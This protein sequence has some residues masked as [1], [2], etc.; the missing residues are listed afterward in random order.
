[1]GNKIKQIV[2]SVFA[3]PYEIDQLGYM[4]KQLHKNYV[5]VDKDI[6]WVIDVSFSLS[7]TLID[8]E[9]SEIPQEYFVEKLEV[10]K[11]TFEF[12]KKSIRA[13]TEI[14]GAFDQRRFITKEYPNADY[15]VWLD[16]DVV[17][18]DHSLFTVQESMKTI[19][20]KYPLSI[21]TPELVKYFDYTW[22]HLVN[23]NFINEEY[24]YQSK[25]DAFKDS[26]IKGE[27]KL[28]TVHCN[29][30]GHPRYKFGGGLFSIISRELLELIPLPEEGLKPYGYEDTFL[31]WAM[32]IHKRYKGADIHQFKI[33]NMVVCENFTHQ[34]NSYYT[35]RLVRYSI[36]EK[37]LEHNGRTLDQILLALHPGLTAEG[38]KSITF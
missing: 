13:T 30:I 7:D 37:Y 6:D 33:K 17:F 22:D 34:D 26:G 31:M 15:Y 36:K 19:K 32:E 12:G 27:V 10:L 29:D 24:H 23:E 18:S 38:L 20:G 14:N 4:L 1:M 3:L 25:N 2:V 11:N 5:W 8:W 35:N 9:K 16:P 21:I 28:T